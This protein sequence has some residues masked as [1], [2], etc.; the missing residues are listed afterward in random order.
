MSISILLGAI[1]ALLGETNKPTVKFFTEIFELVFS[2]RGRVNFTNLS[3]YSHYNESTFRRHFGQNYDWLSLNTAIIEMS[4]ASVSES[5]GGR[6]AAIDCSF[7]P[8]SGD[9]TFGLD[10]YWSGSAGQT[11]KGL[12][13]SALAVIDVSSGRAWT[14]DVVQTPAHLNRV[15]D[16]LPN[17]SASVAPIRRSKKEV[18]KARKEEQV[19]QAA[20]QVAKA[21]AQ[22]QA[23]VAKAAAR[24]QVQIETARAKVEAQVAKETAKKERSASQAQL[25]IQIKAIVDVD[26]RKAAQKNQKTAERMQRES[27]KEQKN[28]EKATRKAAES[29]QKTAKKN[30]K[31]EKKQAIKRPYTR[32]DF[33]IEQILDCLLQLKAIHYI[34]ADG[35]YAKT[36]FIQAILGMGK[37]LITKLRPDANL[38]FQW[39]GEHPKKQGP[40]AQY[41]AKVVYDDLSQWDFEGQDAK[42][43][44]LNVYSR[45]CYSPQ[46][47]VWLRV[48]MVVNHPKKRFIL[49]ASTDISQSALQILT[50]YQFRFQIEF[51]FRDAKQFTGLNHCQARD[52]AKLDFHFNMSLTAV[53]LI[54]ALQ[55]KD[56]TFKSMNDLTRKMYNTK[57]VKILLDELSLTAEFELSNPIIQKVINLGAMS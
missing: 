17:E 38:R 36:K 20:A 53:N 5:V 49:L 48:V 21:A 16:S 46:F 30:E 55:I 26:A 35:F 25:Q 52:D 23:Q 50:F 27:E 18:A 4:E 37:H 6:I 2:I 32:I 11:E 29:A 40:K 15:D 54:Q 10:L 24:V 44:Y 9:S 51:L 28:V 41:G 1:F 56:P 31:A 57:I 8:K 3:R 7:I 22:A 47:E 12:E 42:Y 13:I 39:E 43:D 14:L 33:Y 19:L 45:I 34:V